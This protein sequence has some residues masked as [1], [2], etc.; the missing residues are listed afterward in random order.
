MS[1]ESVDLLNT[2]QE[3]QTDFQKA[4]HPEI[5]IVQ[6]QKHLAD[7]DDVLVT[8]LDAPKNLSKQTIF[9]TNNRLRSHVFVDIQHVR[10]FRENLRSDVVPS[11]L[12]YFLLDICDDFDID[13]PIVFRPR[14]EIVIRKIADYFD[15]KFEVE[16]HDSDF[17][18]QWIRGL[19]SKECYVIGFPI[20]EMRNPLNFSL[21]V[22][23]CL[24]TASSTDHRNEMLWEHLSEEYVPL[25]AEEFDEGTLEEVALDVISHNYLGPV[26]AHRLSQLPQRLGYVSSS[27]HAGLPARLWYGIKYLEYIE[28]NSEWW[29]KRHPRFEEIRQQVLDELKGQYANLP[30][31]Q[32]KAYISDFQSVQEGVNDF[33]EDENIPSYM[34]EVVNLSDYLG[35]PSATDRKVSEKLDKFLLSEDR[36]KNLAL[37]LKP[38]ILLNLLILY[39][40]KEVDDLRKP[41]LL[42]FKKWFVTKKTIYD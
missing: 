20:S 16:R 32:K 29:E 18:R 24:H 31:S 17:Y 21:I 39:N 40:W 8:V 14:R 7:I 35:M 36:N 2:I 19:K 42:S 11:N 10:Q 6:I 25:L 1:N 30:S 13:A 12:Y 4:E 34:D 28:G 15:E 33:F 22:H 5:P 38:S 9:Q 27:S 37:P 3:I 23:E 41:T 26:Y